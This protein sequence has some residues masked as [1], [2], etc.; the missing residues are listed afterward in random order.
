MHDIIC[1]DCGELFLGYDV[2]FDM[3][4]SVA[5]LL[6]YKKEEEEN[7]NSV[8]FKFYVDEEMIKKS[9]K[10]GQ[11][12][13]LYCDNAIGPAATDK[14]F[15]FIVTR[16]MLYDYVLSKCKDG[17]ERNKLNTILS[18]QA[19]RILKN[20]FSQVVTEDITLIQLYHALFAV[21]DKSVVKISIDDE[22][23]KTALKIL[24]FLYKNKDNTT[25]NRIFQV[26]IYSDVNLYNRNKHHVPDALFVHNGVHYDKKVKCCRY[27]G[28]RLPREFGYYKMRPVVLL[29]SHSAGKT[30]YL[31]SLLD[32][33]RN[34][35]PFNCAGLRA[36][37]LMEDDNLKAFEKNIDRYKAGLGPEKTDFKDVPILNIKIG[38]DTTDDTSDDTIYSFID[39]P[40]EKFIN[41]G[42]WDMNFISEYRRVISRAQHILFFMPPEQIDLGM[43]R[44]DENEV[45]EPSELENNLRLHFDFPNKKKTRSVIYVINKFD[46]L[47]GR[48]NTESLFNV[49]KNTD[50]ASL[51]TDRWNSEAYDALDNA[52]KDYIKQKYFSLFSA[53]D[54]VDL[55]NN[56]GGKLQAVEKHYIPVAPYGED[57]NPADADAKAGNNKV[58]HKGRL[59][60]VPFLRMLATD[61]IIK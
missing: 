6:Y 42:A 48:N 28:S 51:Y 11:T 27:C 21:A 24:S 34:Q 16:N 44:P 10:N 31:L 9:N 35:Q 32:T 38:D 4:E 39:W 52:A 30:S 56:K 13:L 49:I 22:H 61:G 33:I 57:I 25:D 41:T 54:S 19:D 58:I 14:A 17:E 59:A 18:N 43:D 5:S 7:V 53:L 60:G 37:T 20:D 36:S 26:S 15:S 23:V 29:G 50:Q 46:K 45:F 47:E 12:S 2:T 55:M 3:S 1:P 40:G 8:K